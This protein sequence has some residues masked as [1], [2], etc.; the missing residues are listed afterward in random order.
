MTISIPEIS[1]FFVF[2][3]VKYSSGKSLPTT[4]TIALLILKTDED[5][6]INMPEPPNILSTLPNGVSI[7]SNA[8]VPTISNLFI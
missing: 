1:I 5:I 4:E 3:R 7:E 2:K 8:T 6:P